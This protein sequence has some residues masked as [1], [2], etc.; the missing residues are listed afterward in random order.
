MIITSLVAAV[1]VLYRSLEKSNSIIR[2]D[3]IDTSTARE[4][5]LKQVIKSDMELNATVNTL[6]D[7]VDDVHDSCKICKNQKTG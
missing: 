2:Q 4:S 5:I 6:V 7:K 1:G 3:L